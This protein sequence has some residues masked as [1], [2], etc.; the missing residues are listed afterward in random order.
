[1]GP[2]NLLDNVVTEPVE[3]LEVDQQLRFV[4]KAAGAFKGATEHLSSVILIAI[5]II[6]GMMP[7]L[8]WYMFV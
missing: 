2:E 6:T 7:I 1:M 8:L 5:L 3:S 4:I